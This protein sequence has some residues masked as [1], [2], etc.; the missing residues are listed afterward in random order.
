MSVRNTACA[1]K[2]EENQE[3]IVSVWAS[4]REREKMWR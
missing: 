1:K 2:K 4:V 3:K